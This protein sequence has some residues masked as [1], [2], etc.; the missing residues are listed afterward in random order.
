[1]KKGLLALAAGT[2][3]VAGCASSG[4]PSS[5]PDGPKAVTPVTSHD[6]GNV[7]VTDDMSK[8][9]KKEFV[10][11]NEGTSDLKLSNLQVKLLEGC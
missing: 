4:A 7:P 2:L 11:K 9:V 8:A 5:S 6:F 3:V 10:I 1:M